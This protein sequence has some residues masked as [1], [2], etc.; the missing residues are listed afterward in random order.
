[1]HGNV[2]QFCIRIIWKEEPCTTPPHCLRNHGIW[3]TI[4]GKMDTL[5]LLYCLV[6]SPTAAFV[7]PFFW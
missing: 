1:M 5:G 6:Q 7:P 3:N 2:V 4:R